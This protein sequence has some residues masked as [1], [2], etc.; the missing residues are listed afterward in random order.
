M[1]RRPLSKDTRSGCRELRVLLEVPA[2]IMGC[3]PVPQPSGATV[4]GVFEEEQEGQWLEGRASGPA[5][6]GR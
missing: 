4:P 2:G 5:S 1:R 3:L 6:E